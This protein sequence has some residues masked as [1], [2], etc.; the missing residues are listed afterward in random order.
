MFIYGFLFFPNKKGF[1]KR[2]LLLPQSWVNHLESRQGD[3]SLFPTTQRKN[4]NKN[5]ESS[6]KWG[7]N[8]T[9]TKK[10]NTWVLS[11]FG[12]LIAGVG[13]VIYFALFKL[14]HVSRCHSS[15]RAALVVAF[16]SR[17][18]IY[19]LRNPGAFAL[20]RISSFRILVGGLEF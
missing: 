17:F 1:P 4:N 11:Y 20:C 2:F 12:A 14:S 13:T 9:K 15:F 10:T 16:C 5:N 19:A 6:K 3:G 18:R 8:K 7:K